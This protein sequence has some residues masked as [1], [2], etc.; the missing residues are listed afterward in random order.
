MTYLPYHLLPSP[1][2]KYALAVLESNED[3]EYYLFAN[4]CLF[5]VFAFVQLKVFS[6]PPPVPFKKLPQ[7]PAL[8]ILFKPDDITSSSLPETQSVTSGSSRL[9]PNYGPGSSTFLRSSF[10]LGEVDPVMET[11]KEVLRNVDNHSETPT[12]PFSRPFSVSDS[13]HSEEDNADTKMPESSGK[14]TFDLPDS[15]AP[16]LSSSQT[17]MLLH[18]LTADLIHGIH[19]EASVRMRAGRHEIPLDKD[20]SRPQFVVDVPKGGCRLSAIA[21]VGSDRFS[22]VQDLDVKIPTSSRS[23]PM[24]KHAGLVFDPPLPLKNVAPTLIHFPT[25]FEDNTLVP[26]LRSIHIIRFFMNAVVAFNFWIEKLLWIVESFLQIHL[27]KIRI[28]PVYKGRNSLDDTSPEWRLT[29]A[30]SGHVMLFGVIPIPFISIVLP[31][32]IMPQPH[33]LLDYLLSKQ[34][35]A[36]A[37]IR[38]ENIAEQRVA[39]AIISTAESWTAK[40]EAVATPPAVGIDLTLSGGVSL[41]LELMHGRDPIAGR[42]RQDAGDGSNFNLS[43]DPFPAAGTGTRGAPPSSG[44]SLSSWTTNDDSE[45]VM[46]RGSPFRATNTE[47]FD[48][49][50]LVPWK[51]E[52]SAKG[53]I[54]DE[55]MSFHLLNCSFQNEDSKSQFRTRG[56]FVVWKADINAKNDSN[57]L[58]KPYAIRR[59]ASFTRRALLASAT[60]TPSVAEIFLFPDDDEGFRTDNKM[61]EYDYAFDVSEDSRLDAI[62]FSVGANHPMLDGGTMLTTILESIYAYGS[63]SARQHAILD[64]MERKRKRNILRHLPVSTEFCKGESVVSWVC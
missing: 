38:R 51:F 3:A 43:K 13:V 27:G 2:D 57:S 47:P 12:P 49:N 30:F 34:P 37:T 16:L 52:L 39:L 59:S 40:M 36:S 10:N 23:K 22:S 54:D 46:R 5:I 64:P 45:S 31:I 26:K 58:S 18:Q 29:L 32:F 15:F 17:E 48:A 55:K 56:S 14:K 50:N 33:A 6:R 9:N 53:T 25:L 11:V 62:T 19:T 42:A 7:R 24:V 28:T 8:S 4:L 20:H 60:G 61:L 63:V 41:G 44:A 35:L 21:T 1:L